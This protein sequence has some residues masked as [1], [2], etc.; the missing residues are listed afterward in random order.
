MDDLLHTRR[1][2]LLTPLLASLPLLAA[3][4]GASA[5]PI[6]P[7]QTIVKPWDQLVWKGQAGAPAKSVESTVLVG[8]PAKPGLYFMMVRWYPGFMSAPH[9]YETDRFCVVVSGTWWVNSGVDFDPAHAVP[10]PQGTFITRVAGTP[11]YDGV[12]AGEKEA[13]MIAI[14][15]MGPLVQTRV[16][17]QVLGVQRI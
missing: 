9:K 10:A 11:H 13:A 2:L 6:N 17:P 15:G 12:K 4:G 7:A 14:C 5:S 8:D 3:A 1:D 16:N